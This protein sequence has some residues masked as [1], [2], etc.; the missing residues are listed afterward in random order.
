[1]PSTLRRLGAI[2][3]ALLALGLGAC[4]GGD[5]G[6]EEGPAAFEREGFP[7]T[8][9]YP[10]D[11]E[12]SEDVSLDQSLGSEP[13]ET[14]AVSLDDENAIIVQRFILNLAVDE[15]NL[16]LARDEIDKLLDQVD[17]EAAS[18]ATKVGGLPALS[19]EDLVVPTVEE[20]ESD[21]TILFDG[22]EEYVINCQSTTDHRTEV[23]EAC[24]TAIETLTAE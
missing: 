21:L 11:W 14:L 2:V 10:G 9:E 24:E 18:E 8:F 4:G 7:F 20:G 22:D 3:F 16:D 5:D 6:E 1:M 17:P 23:E 19:V 13:D 12:L 15:K